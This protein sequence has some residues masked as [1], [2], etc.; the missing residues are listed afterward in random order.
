MSWDGDNDCLNC[1]L[2][3]DYGLMA[4]A[5]PFCDELCERNFAERRALRQMKYDLLR[6]NARARWSLLLTWFRTR[7][8]PGR[9]RGIDARPP[10]S[11]GSP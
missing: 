11:H 9:R 5:P 10:R 3:L 1:G 6:W 8:G 4:D 7:R 2:T